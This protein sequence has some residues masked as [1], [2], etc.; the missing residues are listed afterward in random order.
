MIREKAKNPEWRRVLHEKLDAII[1]RS[2]DFEARA[3]VQPSAFGFASYA[4]LAKSPFRRD[5]QGL[6]RAATELAAEATGVPVRAA[7]LQAPAND[8]PGQRAALREWLNAFDPLTQLP[9]PTIMGNDFDDCLAEHT[10][11]LGLRALDV[12]EVWDIFQPG[13]RG[14]RPA[15][16]YSLSMARLSALEWKRRLLSLGH[17]EG[18]AN[19][20]ITAAYG[21]QWDTIRKWESSCGVT[22]GK[23]FVAAS[24]RRADHDEKH[25]VAP[26]SLF[27][28]LMDP[29]ATR[30]QRSGDKYRTE[31]R[32]AA[33]LSPAKQRAARKSEKQS[34]Q[35]SG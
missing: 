6:L 12:G 20:Q 34:A 28:K 9:Q 14:N 13:H 1:D 35:I 4:Y 24:L 10:V 18:E 11:W 19:R 21:E 33:E 22:L 25:H 17:S 27:G 32:R 31:K 2:A 30:L 29:P 23:D 8:G 15:N 3:D 7:A 26:R 16:L 5:A